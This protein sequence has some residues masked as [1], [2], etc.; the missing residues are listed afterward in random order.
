M[1]VS[2]QL[3]TGYSWLDSNLVLIVQIGKHC[4]EKQ[5]TLSTCL[6]M[7]SWLYKL[8]NLLLKHPHG[9]IPV[10]SLQKQHQ[11]K[12]S[13]MK[14]RLPSRDSLHGYG[15]IPLPIT[16]PFLSSCFSFPGFFSFMANQLAR[17]KNL[18]CW[19][20]CLIAYSETLNLHLDLVN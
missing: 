6:H 10:S 7:L 20:K 18:C 17:K 15:F 5:H 1:L 2:A 13:F 9:T 12:S 14:G 8:L 11:E 3:K 19:M 16:A 4:V